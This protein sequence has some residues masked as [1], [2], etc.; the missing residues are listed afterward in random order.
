MSLLHTHRRAFNVPPY[1]LAGC[2]ECCACSFSAVRGDAAKPARCR[3]CRG[4]PKTVSSHSW[5]KWQKD[6]CKW[7]ETYKKSVLR[8]C[9]LCC[10]VAACDNCLFAA[11]TLRLASSII[12]VKDLVPGLAPI[13]G[14]VHSRRSVDAVRCIFVYSA[15]DTSFSIRMDRRTC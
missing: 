1:E 13:S 3:L 4:I 6:G 10:C 15:A 9:V 5:A 7:K 8:P 11:N 12:I 14:G 2:P